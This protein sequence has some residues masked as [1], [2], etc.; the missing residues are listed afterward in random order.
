MRNMDEGDSMK[1]A[2][3]VPAVSVV[4]P[5]YNASTTLQQTMASAARQTVRDIE[6]IVVDDGSTDSSTAIVEKLAEG[7]P[8]IRLVK[9]SNGGVSS[10]RNAG[11]GAAR[12]RL[13]ALL[14]SD[15]LW[16]PD[17]LE[18]HVRRMQQEPRLGVSFSPARFID[19]AGRH[20]GI[21]QPK[22]RH[23]NP[24]DLLV[25]NPT[26]TCST[27]VIR[28]DVFKD[29]GLFRT[30]MRHN[31]DQEWLFRVTLSGW[32]LAG[33][34]TPRVDY[35]TSP[36]GLA[37][38]L[39]GMLSG[40][41][42]MIVEAR[43]LAPVLVK[44]EEARARASMLRY[45]ARRAIRLG[46][47]QAVARQYILRAVTVA[48]ILALRQPAATLGTLVAAFLPRAIVRPVLRRTQSQNH[49]P[50]HACTVEA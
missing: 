27:L 35:R 18:T 19:T 44:R 12:A 31:E 43:K 15:D 3:R 29:V 32:R 7:D 26:T 39:D 9:Q 38:D 23:I 22:L 28:R 40:F 4:L 37:S 17:H 1:I 6:I 42:T 45:L 41:E 5:C 50:S 11:I 8:R 33:D 30:A 46:L 20:I 13:V 2:C 36:Q 21:S 34:P 16:A 10:A 48:P 47:P 25:S 24:A 14:D 49:A